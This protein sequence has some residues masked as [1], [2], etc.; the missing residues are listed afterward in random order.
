MISLEENLYFLE[1][2]LKALDSQITSQQN[3]LAT[4]EQS[5]T[6]L[7]E[8]FLEMKNLLAASVPSKPADTRPPHY[9]PDTW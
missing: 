2:K 1:E 7:R 5:V 4:I 3:E 9:G 6:H 8:V